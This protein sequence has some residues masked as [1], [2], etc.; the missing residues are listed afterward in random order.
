MSVE[1]SSNLYKPTVYSD[2]VYETIYPKSCSSM[3]C[4][5]HRKS[6]MSP[7]DSA[8]KKNHLYSTVQKLLQELTCVG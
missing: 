8:G 4:G 1:E 5:N 3:S 6:Y 2:A 7:S